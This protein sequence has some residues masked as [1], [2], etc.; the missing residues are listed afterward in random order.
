MKKKKNFHVRFLC[1]FPDFFHFLSPPAPAAPLL[2]RSRRTATWLSTLLDESSKVIS[3]TFFLDFFLIFSLV[4]A[5]IFLLSS[6]LFSPYPLLGISFFSS[7][8]SCESFCEGGGHRY[9][10][11]GGA[12]FAPWNL[13]GTPR[14]NSLLERVSK[15]KMKKKS[16]IN[17]HDNI[18]VSGS[19]G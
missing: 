2:Q 15:E 8:S 19:Q 17:H 4:M 6:C 16:D 10:G 13:R 11:D 1:S 9:H 12:R 5:S 7:S 18:P 3:Q 14:R